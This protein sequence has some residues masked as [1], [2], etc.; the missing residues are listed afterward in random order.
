MSWR[1]ALKWYALASLLV[2]YYLLFE[3]GPIKQQGQHEG[4]G[5]VLIQSSPGDVVEIYVENDRGKARFRRRG[6]RWEAVGVSRQGVPSDLVEAMVDGLTSGQLVEVV[7]EDARNLEVFGL[8]RPRVRINIWIRGRQ[9]PVTLLLGNHTPTGTAVY[10]KLAES[11]KIYKVGANI[12]YY[13]DQLLFQ[14][15]RRSG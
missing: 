5:Q 15:D 10:G 9:K 13:Q 8:D 14:P 1:R 6:T 12:Y 3:R 7:R 4:S 2:G 11:S